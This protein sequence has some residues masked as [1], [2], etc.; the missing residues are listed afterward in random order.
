M[1]ATTVIDSITNIKKGAS[2]ASF[3]IE[4]QGDGIYKYTSGT[5]VYRTASEDVKRIYDEIN[6]LV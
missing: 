2:V 6:A 5:T 4:H 1:T 3:T